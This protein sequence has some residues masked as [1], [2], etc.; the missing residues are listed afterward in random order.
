MSWIGAIILL[1]VLVFVHEMG[2]LLAGLAVG[3][4][5]EAF[6]IGFGPIIFKKEIKGI[7]FRLS[8]IPF[9]GYC[10]FKG[11]ISEDG[12]TEEGDFLNMSP[13]KRIIVYFAGPFFNYL[14][15]F[16]LLAVLVSLPSKIELYS[17]TVSV[18][19]DG[20]YMHSKSGMTLAYEYGIQSGDTITAVNGRKVESDND[21]LKTINDEAIQKAADKIVF[22]LDRNGETL[23]VTIPSVE[24][25]KALSGERALGLYFGDDLIIKNVLPDSA[26]SE[27]GL[28]NGDKIVSINGINA[29]NIAD[30][31]PI[32]MDNASQKITITVIRNGEEVTREAI[33]RPVESK[34][35]GTYG[36]LGVEFESTSMRVERVPG[37]PFPQSIP[38]AFKETGNYLVSYINGLKLLFTGKL[39]VRENLGGPVRIIQLSSQVI[40]VD[41]EYRLRT[42]LSFTATISLILFIM[43]LLPLPVVDGGMIVFSF[44]ELIMRRPIDRKVL[45]K[46]QT[47][48]AAFLITLAIFITINDIT[49]LFR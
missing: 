11:E 41:I 24:M 18:F 4:K 27:A 35:I 39:S 26:A 15:A 28:M 19:K 33:P 8:I 10:K 21:I 38:E 30:F 48:G 3:I 44:I 16:L 32:V 36:S 29:R 12:K 43:N 25:L 22:T 31:R 17:P 46:I 42:I 47:I 14:F 37:I 40:S 13:L 20:R 34:T 7:D 5:A 49:Q 1:S 6:S 9:G 23:N 2:H 45:T